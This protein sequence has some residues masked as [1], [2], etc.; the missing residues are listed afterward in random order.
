M[1]RLTWPPLSEDPEKVAARAW[2]LGWEAL[3]AY[4]VGDNQATRRLHKTHRELERIG[5]EEPIPNDPDN[6]T[7][8][9]LDDTG[10]SVLLEDA[11]YLLFKSAV[12]ALRER[13]DRWGNPVLTGAHTEP[14]M[15]LDELLERAPEEPRPES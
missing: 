13:K 9:K 5:V 14:L 15:W 4:G 1:R 10:G 6:N 2:V 11:E 3:N 8:W 12:T 7:R